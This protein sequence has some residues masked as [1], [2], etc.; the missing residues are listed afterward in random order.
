MRSKHLL[1]LQ[2][3]RSQIACSG[4]AVAAAFH[5]TF[6]AAWQAGHHTK[7]RI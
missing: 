1:R 3:S 4:T 2:Q 6:E 5:A 7:L